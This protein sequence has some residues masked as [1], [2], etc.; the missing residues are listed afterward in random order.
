MADVSDAA[1][2]DSRLSPL[3][4][5]SVGEDLD[6]EERQAVA[7]RLGRIALGVVIAVALVGACG[8]AGPLVRTEA[9]SGDLTVEY[10]RFS[11]LDSP[12]EIVVSLPPGD[13]VFVLGADAA[14]D[15]RLDAVQP[16]PASEGS[17]RGGGLRLTTT[18]G[19][20]VR[21]HT[22]PMRFGRLEGSVSLADGRTVGL[23]LFVYP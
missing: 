2:P 16:T 17:M 19:A 13:S 18:P 12:T 4:G 14:R 21:L 22:R 11:R 10:D 5:V 8:G 7:G 9:V 3:P 6:H 15:L 1:L 20:V 23:H